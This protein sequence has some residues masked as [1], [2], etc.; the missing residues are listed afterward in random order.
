MFKKC[1]WPVL[2]SS[3]YGL[4]RF[5]IGIIYSDILIPATSDSILSL[6]RN[7]T[8]LSLTANYGIS[9]FA[10]ALLEQPDLFAQL[11]RLSLTRGAE[12]DC[13][14]VDFKDALPRGL[15]YLKI[16]NTWS[17]SGG[18]PHFITSPEFLPPSLTHLDIETAHF[19]VLKGHGFPSTLTTI[20]ARFSD[21]DIDWMKLLPAGLLEC[22]MRYC[23]MVQSSASYD[24]TSLP[25]GLTVLSITMGNDKI[26]A[27]HLK[28]LPPSITNLY[29]SANGIDTDL[30]SLLPPSLKTFYGCLPLKAGVGP[31]VVK[32]LPRSIT[33]LQRVHAQAV[34]FLPPCMK[35]LSLQTS[36]DALPGPLPRSLKTLEMSNCPQDAVNQ[37]FYPPTLS[38]LKLSQM[39]YKTEFFSAFPS[40]LSMLDL[41]V[42]DHIDLNFMEPLKQLSSLTALTTLQLAFTSI[43]KLTNE[44]SSW[45]P[46]S[47]EQLVLGDCEMESDWF[48]S[49]PSSLT[50]LTL[51]VQL[52]RSDAMKHL[53]RCCPQ[54]RSM[55]LALNLW[56]Y[57]YEGPKPN[58]TV[59]CLLSLPPSLTECEITVSISGQ[60]FV[61]LVTNDHLRQ[62]PSSLTSLRIPNS[63]NVTSDCLPFLPKSLTR[64]ILNYRSPQWF[65][66]QGLEE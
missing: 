15:Q 27:R 24:W 61:K 1:I 47:L 5:K 13:Q 50:I 21:L 49:L 40:T 28:A 60:S 37:S 45:L 54:L 55:S 19:E 34:P 23:R 25:R 53:E 62:L 12:D 65:M 51:Q 38:S 58:A 57:N 26:E 31:E 9:S 46:R 36:T 63:E 48:S 3:L 64:F 56:D 39:T 4:Q 10:K 42:N 33:D 6:P 35:I 20:H 22:H 18:F 43:L 2:A 52:V 14:N 29:L 59:D 7:L 8:S 44:S 17:H 11:K 66:D 16:H 41:R 32:K 30:L